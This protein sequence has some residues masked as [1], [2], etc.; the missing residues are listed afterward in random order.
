M[1]S[2]RTILIEDDAAFAGTARQ[3]LESPGGR[4]KC[5]AVYPNAERALEN[6]GKA[7][8]DV[9]LV[10]INLPGMN[11]IE[12]IT[13]LRK[14]HP[15]TLCLVL[16]AFDHNKLIFDALKAGA[17]GYMLK[18]S[19]PA[20]IVSAIEQAVAGGSPMSPHI[21]RKVVSYF[22]RTS[23]P[24]AETTLDEEERAVIEQLASGLLYKEIATRLGVTI[25]VVRFRVKK[26]YEKLHAHSRM[27]AVNKY[28][29]MS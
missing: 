27:E 17:C 3:L 20:D 19:A 26:V 8:P 29:G 13:R 15:A 9:A 24:T 23:Q 12:C 18:R 22:H 1:K 21:A 25:D 11:G 14:M 6:V 16:T 28:R 7:R 2:I 4:V 5:V 10:D